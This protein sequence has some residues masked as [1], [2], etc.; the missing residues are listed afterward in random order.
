MDLERGLTLLRC[1]LHQLHTYHGHGTRRLVP[2]ADA[3]SEKEGDRESKR[4]VS[5]PWMP[6]S[7]GTRYDLDRFHVKERIDTF[8]GRATKAL[9]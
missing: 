1:S 6:S 8:P 5:T 9:S 2:G 7:H 4:T 3:D